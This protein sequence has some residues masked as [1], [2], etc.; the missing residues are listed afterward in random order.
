MAPYSGRWPGAPVVRAARLRCPLSQ[1]PLTPEMPGEARQMWPLDAPGECRV[2][3]KKTGR[4]IPQ[5]I[6]S[7]LLDVAAPAE[8]AHDGVVE[9]PA[10][11]QIGDLDAHVVDHQR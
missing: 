3:A 4:T 1:A 10:S 7:R 11:L 8:R 2:D 5:P 6:R 9:P